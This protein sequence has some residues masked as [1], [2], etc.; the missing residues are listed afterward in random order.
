MVNRVHDKKI[1]KD[2]IHIII[3]IQADHVTQQVLRE[4]MIIRA[5]EMWADFPITNKWENVNTI[6]REILGEIK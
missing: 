4:Q 5:K 2:G 1:T 6:I 3:G